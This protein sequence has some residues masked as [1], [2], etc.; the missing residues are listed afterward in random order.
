MSEIESDEWLVSSSFSNEFTSHSI[1]ENYEAKRFVASESFYPNF[2]GGYTFGGS[3]DL[4]LYSRSVYTFL[5]LLGDCGGLFDCLK[6]IGYSVIVFFNDGNL[7]EFL[8]TRIFYQQKIK[9]SRDSSYVMSN[10][11]IPR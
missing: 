8:I 5:D 9:K 6:L 10:N 2:V 4:I 3:P 1:V 7:S 11:L